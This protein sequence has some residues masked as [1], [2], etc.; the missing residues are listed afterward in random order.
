MKGI[1]EVLI[2]IYLIPLRWSNRLAI[3]VKGKIL[4]FDEHYIATIDVAR[5]EFSKDEGIIVDVGAYDADSSIY[6]AKAF[7]D[8]KIVALE[9][10]PEPYNSA[11]KN[12]RRYKNIELLNIGLS[13]AVGQADFFITTDLVSSSLLDPK[14]KAEA[15]FK[16]KLRVEVTTLDTLFHDTKHILLIK[17]DVQGAELNILRHGTKSLSKTRL[18]LTEM[19]NSDMYHGSCQYNELDDLLRANGIQ[20]HSLFSNYNNDGA[21]YFDAL[22]INRSLSRVN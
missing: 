18:V 20:L 15:R 6:F 13:N 4:T 12:T 9:P 7:P 11:I 22:Y 17:L 2:S 14:L 10:N 3:Y 8:R 1:I 5:R 16:A 21:K 19:W